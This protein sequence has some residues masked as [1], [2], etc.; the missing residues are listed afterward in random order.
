MEIVLI[1]NE[2]GGTGK[3]AMVH[4][5]SN[6]LTALGYRVLAVDFDPSG[7]LSR[8][9]LQEEPKHVLYEVFTGIC[10]LDSAIYHTE[11]C[12]ILPTIKDLA[13]DIAPADTFLLASK[14]SK[15]LTQLADRLVGRA[16]AEAMLRNLL[17]SKKHDLASRYDFVIIDSAPSDNIL[18]TNA[19]VAADSILIP[20]EPSQGGL[21]G[22]WMF[23]STVNTA[24]NAYTPSNA[25]VDGIV[26]SKY[27]ED[28]ANFVESI[29][30]IHETA[31]FKDLY[32]YNTVMRDSKSIPHA[33]GHC[34]P[35]LSYLNTNG[36]G[37]VDA[38]NLALEF[39]EA[40][41]LV[42]KT[43]FPGVQTNKDGSLFFARPGKAEKPAASEEEL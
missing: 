41:S 38:L 33:M 13:L 8:S 24:N 25:K 9:V 31:K 19:I 7:N 34:R 12:D 26:I 30:A 4:T 28:G 5:L 42:P 43:D 11:I 29:Q 1:A 6:A 39:L 10:D 16:G 37:P 36:H 2:K 22:V 40:R 14:D 21:D 18:V 23:L 15:S 27:T 17:R 20:C 3:S 35:I 32:L